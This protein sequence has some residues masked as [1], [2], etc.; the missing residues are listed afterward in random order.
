MTV[1][2][3]RDVEDYLVELIEILYEKEYFGFKESATQYVRELVLEIRDTISKK[4]KKAA[5]EYFSKYGKDLF[6]ASFRRNKNT[7]WYVF[8]SFSA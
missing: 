6:Y 1:Q 3:H 7:S 5:P 8:F 2:F 4:R